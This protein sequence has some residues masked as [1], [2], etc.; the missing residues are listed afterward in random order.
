MERRSSPLVLFFDLLCHDL[1]VPKNYE[2]RPRVCHSSQIVFSCC[3]GSTHYIGQRGQKVAGVC[4]YC[5]PLCGSI[6]D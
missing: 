4:F 5:W 3:S 2:Q 1:R 6:L